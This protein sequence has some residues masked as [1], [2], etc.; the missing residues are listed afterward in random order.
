MAMLDYGAILKV[1]GV[2]QNHELFDDNYD[3]SYVDE[4][5]YYPKY[6][7][8]IDIKDSFYVYGGDK[9]MYLC[10]YKTWFYVV[11]KGVVIDSYSPY[12]DAFNSITKYVWV[13]NKRVDIK[14]DIID[15]EWR[16]VRHTHLMECESWD[17][18]VALNYGD[19]AVGEP[20][21]NLQNG[22]EYYKLWLKQCRKIGKRPIAYKYRNN[23]YYATW[24]WNGH[25]YE[26][27]FGYGIDPDI[28]VYKR[29]T[30]NGS[31]NYTNVEIDFIDKFMGIER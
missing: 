2:I 15:K 3:F 8:D 1:D 18:F 14:V 29:I 16:E 20:I 27:V 21:S 31:Y 28:D 10:F 13:N 22:A 19:D 7:I 17:D 5:A 9:D 30:T 26:V 12:G 4:K 24:E 23:K 6:E 25:K 11:S